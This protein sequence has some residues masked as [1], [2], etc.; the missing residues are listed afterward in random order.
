[1]SGADGRNY[2]VTYYRN[3]GAY[4][5]PQS[6]FGIYPAAVARARE[7]LAEIDDVKCVDVWKNGRHQRRLVTRLTPDPPAGEPYSPEAD[8]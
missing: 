3:N 5:T 2:G 7:L 1:V 6:R 4:N 8:T